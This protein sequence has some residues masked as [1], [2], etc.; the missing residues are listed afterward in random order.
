MDDIFY[1]YSNIDNLE[2]VFE[3]VKRNLPAWRLQIGPE[4][5]KEG[6]PLIIQAEKQANKKLDPK[7]Y[8]SGEVD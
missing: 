3:D 1:A 6:T 8:K 2:K 5:Y 7:R 4:K